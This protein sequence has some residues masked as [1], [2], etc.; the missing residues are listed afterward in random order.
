M[1]TSA[2]A[3]I[4]Q[5][6]GFPP[7][8]HGLQEHASATVSSG[9]ARRSEERHG[10]GDVVDAAVAQAFADDERDGFLG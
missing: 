3:C 1:V 10:C 6:R 4:I 8:H 5:A 7:F 9:G 2:D